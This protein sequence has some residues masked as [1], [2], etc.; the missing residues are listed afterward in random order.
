MAELDVTVV[1]GARP[2][3][4]KVAPLLRAFAAQGLTAR[5]VNAGQHNSPAM[6]GDLLRELGMPVP[7]ADLRIGPGTHAEQT[8][9]G[10]LAFEREF[11]DSR[12]AALVVVGDVNTTLTAAL[13]AAKLSI[14]IAHV[15]AGLRSGDRSMP[16]EINRILTDHLSSWLFTTSA[17]SDENLAREG[18]RNDAIRLVGNVMVDTLLDSLPTALARGAALRER[19]ALHGDFGIVTLHRPSNVDSVLRLD[20]LLD[21]IEQVARDLPLLFSVHPRTQAA[22]ERRGKDLPSGVISAPPLAYLDFIG[23]LSRA[24]LVLTD[25]GGV[26]EETSVL[27][28]PC[29]TLRDTTERPITCTAG[30]NAVLGPDVSRLPAMVSE[31]LASPRSTSRPVIPLWDGRAAGRI[32]AILAKD[33]GSRHIEPLGDRR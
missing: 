4:V 19:L 29:I 8:A 13:T 11:L 21:L 30:T 24:R 17:D 2:N 12:P 22:F 27:G 7:D 10:M 1:A 31:V 6:A 20:A 23:L 3:F 14:P 5:L 33:L 15:E 32:A 26:Q 25:S 9:R 16:E 18:I 28:V